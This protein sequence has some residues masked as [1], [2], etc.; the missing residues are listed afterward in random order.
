VPPTPFPAEEWVSNLH[1]DDSLHIVTMTSGELDVVLE[2][3][4]VTLRPGDSVI[5]PGRAHDLR[6]STDEPASFIYT[7]FPLGAGTETGRTSNGR[8]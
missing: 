5:L 3:G 4:E 7:S 8:H 2:V 6:N 1:Y